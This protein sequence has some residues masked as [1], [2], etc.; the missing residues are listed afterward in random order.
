M[1]SR[2][3]VLVAFAAAAG[4]AGCSGT[5]TAIPPGSNPSALSSQ[6]SAAQRFP[7]ANPAATAKPTATPTPVVY[8]FKNGDQFTYSFAYRRDSI[9]G[10]TYTY[11][12]LDATLTS[13]LS[14][15][16]TYNGV[17]A[18]ELRSSGKTSS[19][20]TYPASLDYV[21]Y[22]NLISTGGHTEYVD[23]GYDHSDVLDKCCG[24]TEY[25]DTKVAYATPFVENVL[26]ETTGATW[27][28]Q[29]AIKETVND[30]DHTAQNSPNILSGTL[31]RANDGSYYGSGMNYDVPETRDVRSDGTGYV[32]DGPASAPVE[33]AFALPEPGKSGNVIPATERYAGKSGTNLVPDWYPG[34]DAPA[35]PL[36]SE[37]ARDLGSAK[38]P[39]ECGKQAG[40]GAMHIES[41]YSQLDPIVGFTNKEVIDNYVVAGKGTICTIDQVLEYDYDREV[42][43]KL[44]KTIKTSTVWV[45]LSEILK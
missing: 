33:W 32:I 9:K 6:E 16:T 34:G 8:P 25:D 22:M 14:G 3:L 23:Y 24:V 5:S 44:T 27:A 40:T 36:A 12:L 10:S 42:T 43:G 30:Y 31:T 20:S 7:E 41:T 18:Y 11:V 2:I 39:S 37:T 26:P 35:K 28:Q 45:L 1:R 17:P 4:V 13:V 29:V 19:G 21:D 38:A 15:P